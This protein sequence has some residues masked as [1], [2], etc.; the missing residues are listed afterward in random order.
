MSKTNKLQ[1]KNKNAKALGIEAVQALG[2]RGGGKE[3]AFQGTVKAP[4]EEIHRFFV[5]NSN[6]IM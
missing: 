4:R 2:G 5:N 6:F 1:S 3:Q